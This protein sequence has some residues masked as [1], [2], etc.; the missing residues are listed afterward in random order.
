MRVLCAQEEELKAIVDSTWPACTEADP[1]RPARPF[2]ATAIIANPPS[3]SYIA[4]AEKLQVRPPRSRESAAR[5]Q[6]AMEWQQ[7]LL[8]RVHLAST[9][10]VPAA[11]SAF[12]CLKAASCAVSAVNHLPRCTQAPHAHL[13]RCTQAP[14]AHLPRCTQAPHAPT[15]SLIPQETV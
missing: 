11:A 2:R 7:P 14:H 1:E 15:L 13:P 12:S 8:S 4:C 3:M 5:L 9:P 10:S 6:A